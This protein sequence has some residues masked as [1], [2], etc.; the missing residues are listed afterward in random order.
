MYYVYALQSLRVRQWLYIG[1]SADLKTR[2]FNHSKGKVKSTKTYLPLRLV[3]YEAY[4]HRSDAAQREYE[5]KHNSQQ[6][7]ILKRRIEKSLNTS[8]PTGDHP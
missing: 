3:Y 7:E 8:L 6:K 4:L 2:Y 1:F 5:L